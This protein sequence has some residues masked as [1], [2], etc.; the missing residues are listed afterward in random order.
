[1][2]PEVLQEELGMEEVQ[3]RVGLHHLEAQGYLERAADF[4][5]RGS[6]TF[7]VAPEEALD[8][9]RA[10]QDVRAED[11][12]RLLHYARW[13]AY[14]KLEVDLLNL[15]HALQMTP[16]AIEAIFLRLAQ[17]SEAISK[18]ERGVTDSWVARLHT[19]N[20]CA[21]TSSPDLTM[22][23][24]RP[25]SPNEV[26]ICCTNGC[27]VA[28]NLAMRS[29]LLCGVCIGASPCSSQRGSIV[30]QTNERDFSNFCARMSTTG[31]VGAEARYCPYCIIGGT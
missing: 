4:S 12:A 5:L 2:D 22:P 23:R 1:L 11:L 21:Y 17:R 8:A 27:N 16:V 15:A 7:Q 10:D 14:R 19:P 6:L 31:C 30:H 29:W 9:W 20:P 24:A 25:A 28:A 13:P 3:M 18:I 26:T